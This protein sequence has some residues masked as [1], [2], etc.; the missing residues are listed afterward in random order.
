MDEPTLLDLLRSLE[1][2]RVERKRSGGLKTDVRRAV[3]AFANDLPG[4]GLPGVI[5][6]GVE[7][8]GSCAGETIDDELLKRLSEMR[9]D[10]KLQPLPH[11]TVQKRVLDGCEVAVVEV[12]PADAPPV[13]LDGRVYVRVGPTTR[14]ASPQEERVLTEKRRAR[15][16]PFD[17]RPL[18]SATLEDLDLG[19][20]RRTYLP[21]AVS[22]D[23]LEENQRQLEDQLSSLRM[24]DPKTGFPTV[25]GVLVLGKDPRRFVPGFYVQ[26]LRFDGDDLIDPIK[27]QKELEGP[28]P[29]L[30]SGV[31][32]LLKIHIS[33]T[34]DLVSADR[35]GRHPDYPLVALQQL[36]RNAVL[37]RTYDGTHAPVRISWF[38]DR[39]EIQSPGGPYGQVTTATF[40]Q[41]GVTDYRNPHLAEAMKNLGYVQRFGVGIA[42]ARKELLANGNPPLELEPGDHNV[43]ATLRR[44]R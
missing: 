26:F 32:E 12:A 25:L 19:L 41:P 18:P 3:C 4:H 23:V 43:L 15:D 16:L 44:R 27:D 29:E 40:G 20:F 34:A 5:F 42:L 24:L 10:G 30:L 35:E 31:D 8:D 17:L 7:D 36:A 2:D 37:H 28:L 11:I 14:Q 22:A 6:V 13:R 38:D 39:V 9:S 21:S 33:V 1:S